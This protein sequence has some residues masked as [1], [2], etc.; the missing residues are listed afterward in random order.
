MK[1]EQTLQELRAKA[2]A[3]CADHDRDMKENPDYAK[4]YKAQE[5][6]AHKKAVKEGR[7]ALQPKVG[8]RVNFLHQKAGMIMRGVYLGTQILPHATRGTWEAATIEVPRY[9]GGKHSCRVAC[10][11]TD[12]TAIIGA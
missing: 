6:R 12:I 9:M 1:Q 5:I 2:M 7:S 11:P 3:A 8:D 4:A 10:L